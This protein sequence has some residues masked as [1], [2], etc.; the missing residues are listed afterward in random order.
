MSQVD[1]RL[2]QAGAEHCKGA[3][4]YIGHLSELP[5]VTQTQS[6]RSVV[7]AK[8]QICRLGQADQQTGV[9]PIRVDTFPIKVWGSAGNVLGQ[10][11]IG[12]EVCVIG[13]IE[14]ESWMDQQTQ[15]KRFR[16]VVNCRYVF[17]GQRSRYPVQQYQQQG[18]GQQP[19]SY[20]PPVQQQRAYAPP[21][22][23]AQQHPQQPYYAPVQQPQPSYPVQQ[24]N[25]PVPPAQGQPQAAGRPGVWE[26][27]ASPG[28]DNIPF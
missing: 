14:N 7:S 23:Q 4:T 17:M 1:P 8:I 22:L 20:A 19:Q 6:G 2:N 18:Q 24:P 12:Q 3:A 13:E 26:G 21:A 5:K 25:Y 9:A 16:T 15:Q 28:L 27:Q 11:Q 10:G